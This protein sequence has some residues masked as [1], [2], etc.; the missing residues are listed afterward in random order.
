ML[1]HIIFFF[2]ILLL[3]ACSSVQQIRLYQGPP[4]HTQ[5]EARIFLPESFNIVEF[6]GHA[7]QQSSLRFRVGETTLAIPPGQHILVFQY[8]DIWDVDDENHDTLSTGHIVFKFDA[9]AG[10]EFNIQFPHLKTYEQAM[11]FTQNPNVQLISPS[12]AIEGSH[13]KKK[14]PMVFNQQVTDPVSYPNL[15]QLKF[16]WEQA[17]Q[18]EREAFLTWQKDQDK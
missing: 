14:K 17:T 13:L 8:Q 10:E 15:K 7:V 3:S 18:Y 2:C 9:K 1:R 11:T 6:N 16:W 4:L 12:Q 5:Q